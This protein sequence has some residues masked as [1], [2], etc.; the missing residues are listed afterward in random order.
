MRTALIMMVILVNPIYLTAKDLGDYGPT[1]P[2]LETNLLEFI[3]SKLNALSKEGKLSEL[4]NEFVQNVERSAARPKGVDLPQALKSHIRAFDPSVTLQKDIKNNEGRIV[5]P[6]GSFVNPLK[7]I[8]LSK[9]LV[10]ING[11]RENEISFAKDNIKKNPGDKIILVNGDVKE[12]NFKV[13]LPVY[14]DQESRLINRFGILFTP[15]V[16]EQ[17]DDVL[18][19]KEVVI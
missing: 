10:F 18:L 12:V 16:V 7:Y 14:F 3:F 6:K 8:K 1:Y 9:R 2:I 11:N 5:A 4:K 17:Q 13:G 19:I 15:T